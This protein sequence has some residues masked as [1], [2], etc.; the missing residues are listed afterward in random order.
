MTV[1]TIRSNRKESDD[2]ADDKIR[3]IIRSADERFNVGDVIHFQ[4]YERRKPVYHR[5][6]IFGYMVTKTQDH[7]TAPVEKGFQIISFRR[8][9]W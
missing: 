3:H 6:N 1:L 4:C 9:E 5:G 8:C 7:N 2:I